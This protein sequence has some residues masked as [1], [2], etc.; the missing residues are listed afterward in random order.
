MEIFAVARFSCDD[1]FVLNGTAKLRCSD[2]TCEW[3]ADPPECVP[4]QYIY[5][6][7]VILRQS[8]MIIP[9]YGPP[10]NLHINAKCLCKVISYS[11]WQGPWWQS[12][13]TLAFHH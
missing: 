5:V 13:K 2:F 7:V 11:S 12:G 3:N 8:Y 9:F 10:L 1:D 6:T 4:G